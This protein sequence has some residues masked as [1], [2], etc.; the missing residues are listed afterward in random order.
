MNVK[1]LFDYIEECK[2]KNVVASWQGLK[3][4]YEKMKGRY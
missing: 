2:S 4:Y 1:Y 3:N